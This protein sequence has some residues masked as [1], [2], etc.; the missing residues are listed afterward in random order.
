MEYGAK[1]FDLT[2]EPV[3]GKALP[4]YKGEVLRITQVGGEQC[5]D[6]NAFNLHDY[7]E[8]MSVSNS[9]G[10]RN[11]GLRPRKGDFIWSV[12]SRNRPMYYILEMPTTC[13]TDTLGG[14]CHAGLYPPNVVHTN[15]M[16]TFAQT[17]GEYGLTPDDVHDSFNM[18][19]NT[20]WDSTGQWWIVMNTGRKGDYVDL[21][22]LMDTLAVPIV[23]GSGDLRPTSNFSFKPIRVEVF[24]P[25]NE[26]QA[27]VEELWKPLA[28]AMRGLDD[29][30]VRDIRV[31]RE[32][33]PTQG[34]EPR[35][36]NYPITT[37]T[38]K[39]R[40][41]RSD[42]R[43]LRTLVEKGLGNTEAEALRAAFFS[44]N[45][46]ERF[47]QALPSRGNLPPR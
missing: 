22:A 23:C 19:M 1:R 12:Q 2:L 16:D 42:S 37:R 26:T 44:W 41:T 15:C 25:S 6:F 30:R 35:W 31:E 39:V 7:K 28:P 43:A 20:E 38:L 9:R 11:G 4:V 45:I 21:L 3:T 33:R 5:V 18:W 40:M 32:L 29:F 8:Y 27:R 10:T 46:H 36:I 17:V 14:R 47:K 13:V 24:E 34:Y